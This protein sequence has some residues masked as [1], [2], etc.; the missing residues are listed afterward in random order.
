MLRSSIG[1]ALFALLV[2]TAGSA[3]ADG[4]RIRGHLLGPDMATLAPRAA[5]ARG[6]HALGADMAALAQPS[7][8]RRGGHTLGQD[9]AALDTPIGCAA[10]PLAGSACAP[11][12][13]ALD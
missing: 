3:G 11:E 12:E 4:P 7:A 13:V 8:T 9:M 6:G 10:V 1:V 2:V 5:P